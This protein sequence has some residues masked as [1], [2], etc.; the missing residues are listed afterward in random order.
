MK[1][2][3]ITGMGIISSL[4]SDRASV[5]AS[6]RAGRSGIQAVPARREMGFNSCLA[7]VVGDYE[8][9][10]IPKRL[11]RQM[12]EHGRMALAAANQA[13]EQAQLPEAL[14]Q[15][16]RTALFVGNSGNMHDVFELCHMRKATTKSLPGVSL[17]RTMASSVSANLAVVLKPRGT[18]MTVAGA[19]ASG[20]M[21]VGQAYQL[22]KFGVQDRALA[23]G[24]QEGS[25]EYDCTFD[26]LRVFSKREDEPHAAS[27]PF[28]V[29]RDGVVPSAGAGMLVLESLDS[30]RSRGA[31]ILAELLGY[32]ANTDGDGDMTTGS[33]EG[34]IRCIHLALDDAAIAP[35][36]IDYINAHAT[37]TPVGDRVEAWAIRQVFGHGPF[38]GATK[39][40][41][42]HEIGA[43]GA[44]ELIYTLL[45]MHEQF[46]APNANLEKV[47][48]ECNG[49]RLV[50]TAA[51]DRTFDTALSNSLGFGGVNACLVV[52]KYR[53]G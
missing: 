44:S 14:V 34:A 37:S 13:I 53:D 35:G 15:D 38:V 16:E 50:G 45:M 6:L 4:G 26:A 41:T 19:C 28:D 10:D 39:S 48:P 11:A 8:A 51:V 7:G 46:I 9:P 21:A 30:A 29:D 20:A 2:V 31:P 43:A 5:A 49:I 40:M 22:I 18:C 36:D 23:G 27:R 42:G 17:P 52:R 3:V 12:T 33:G 32:G 25:W 47:D 1:R 24:A